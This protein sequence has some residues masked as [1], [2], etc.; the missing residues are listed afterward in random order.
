MSSFITA[1][2]TAN[3]AFAISQDFAAEWMAR[4]LQMS[5]REQKVLKMLYEASGIERRYTVMEDYTRSP[6]NFDFLPKTDDLEPFPTVSRRM[7]MYKQNALPLAAEAIRN[8]M[9]QHKDLKPEQITHLI[10]VS[11]TGMYAP[12]I[13]IELVEELGLPSHT[14]RTQIQFMGCYAAFNAMKAANSICMAYPGSK[15]LVV[16]V[17]L[18][19]L[20]FQKQRDRDQLV[21]NALFA[22]GAAAMLIESQARKGTASI[23]LST[24]YSELIPQGMKDMA[25]RISDTGFEMTLSSYVPKMIKEGIKDLTDKLLARLSL[26][27]EDIAHFAIHPGGRRILEVCEEELGISHADN[28][29]AYE[30]L[31][32]KG[33]MSSATVVFVLKS[34]LESQ[35]R[36]NNG[37]HLLSFAFG[38][39]LTVESMLGKIVYE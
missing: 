5:P 18:C 22:D 31:R 24:F 34:L 25:W 39:G 1:I 9:G 8:A 32:S 6:E 19:S 36:Q 17:E 16:C 38:P 29:H 10:T 7:D 3:P 12:G 15:V 26:K 27:F 33:N 37:D 14:E 11:C 13:D 35:T 21:S 28:C 30:V 2:G 20:H 23:E 4:A